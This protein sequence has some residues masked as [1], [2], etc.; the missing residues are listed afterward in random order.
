MKLNY[1]NIS[2]PCQVVLAPIWDNEWTDI[3]LL[4]IKMGVDNKTPAY[5]AKHPL[6]QVPMLEDG[7]FGIGESFAVLRY[8]LDS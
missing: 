8:I 2:A 7:D 3:E 1:I 4:N 5:L 6:G